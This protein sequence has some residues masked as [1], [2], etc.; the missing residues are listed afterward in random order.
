MEN[1]KHKSE[2]EK[3]G[4][5]EN[6]NLTTLDTNEGNSE[7]IVAT[8]TD[9]VLAESRHKKGNKIALKIC[10]ILMS[11]LLYAVGIEIFV[12]G[13]EYIPGGAW[14]IALMIETAVPAISGSYWF[15]IVNVPLLIL[16]IVFLGWKFTGYT[17]LFVGAQAGFSALIELFE[18]PV[19]RDNV[20][21]ATIAASVIMGVGQA[22]CLKVGGCT[23]GTD[24]IS[25]ILQKKK[26][27]LNVPYVIF[28]VNAIIIAFA[29]FV[30]NGI[31]TLILSLLLEF[32]AAK[33][34]DTL[35]SGL[36]S[37]VRFE[38]VT[39]KGKEVQQAIVN[40]LGSGATIVEARGGYTDDPKE[41]LICLIHKRQMSAFKRTLKEVDPHAFAYISIVTSVLGKGFT[42]INSLD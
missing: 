27:P 36:S 26:I 25:V 41:V 38:I 10:A 31:T 33:V 22:C 30:M 24:I 28:I 14:G 7:P 35:L 2:I 40:K 9:E 20:L 37:A 11:A 29:F 12:S 23:G 34:S 13:N 42:D 1:N 21:L 4:W 32:L 5:H 18:I 8:H 16:S 15:A 39:S 19:Y 6:E 17:F 3:D